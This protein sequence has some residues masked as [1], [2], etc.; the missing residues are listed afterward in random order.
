MRKVSSREMVTLAV[1]SMCKP[2]DGQMEFARSVLLEYHLDCIDSLHG[3]IEARAWAKW[4]GKA[5]ISDQ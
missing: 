2:I 4:Q 5:Q 3:Q 1:A